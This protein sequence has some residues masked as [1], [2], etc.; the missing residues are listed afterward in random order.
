LRQNFSE[1][2]SIGEISFKALNLLAE[3]N[4]GLSLDGGSSTD[5]IDYFIIG[6]RHNCGFI[7]NKFN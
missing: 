2:V 4:R 6:T 5:P 7:Y 3:P 1:E